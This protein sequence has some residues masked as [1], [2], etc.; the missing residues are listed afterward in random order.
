MD[1]NT[2]LSARVAQAETELSFREIRQGVQAVQANYLAR[3]RG[4]ELSGKPMEGRAKREAFATFYAALHHITVYE[5]MKTT[6]LGEFP[7]IQK[8]H[9]L[10]CGTGAVGSAVALS[11]HNSAIVCGLDRSPWAIAEARQCYAGLGLSGGARKATLPGGLPK[12][13]SGEI[14]VAGWSLNELAT[15]ARNG[16]LKEFKRALGRG[17]GLLIFEPISEKICPWWPTWV[18]ELQ[19]FNVEEHRIKFTHARPEWIARMDKAAK[20]DHRILSARVLGCKPRNFS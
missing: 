5:W 2:W 12:I 7:P 20:M 6:P 14:M 8:I 19:G 15:D 18:Q 1:F 17:A 13:G 4:R 3:Q 10:G 16:M 11:M 9:D